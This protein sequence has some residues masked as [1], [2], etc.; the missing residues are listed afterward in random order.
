MNNFLKSV[1]DW[2]R[3]RATRSFILKLVIVLL[4]I[5][6]GSGIGVY[7]HEH[8][9]AAWFISIGETLWWMLVVMTKA[10]GYGPTSC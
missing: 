7:Y 6:I 4:V 1:L 10:P 8:N 5:L 9:N 2:I 3:H